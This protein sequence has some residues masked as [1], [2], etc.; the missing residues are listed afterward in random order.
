MEKIAVLL[1]VF[2]SLTIAGFSQTAKRT[3]TNSD[4]A[5]FSQKR[6]EAERE[7][8]QTYAEKGLPS[9]EEIRAQSDARVKETVE[10]AEKIQADNLERQRL[11][12]AAMQAQAQSQPIVITQGAPYYYPDYGY[13]GFGSDGIFDRFGNRFRGRSVNRRGYYAAGGV[14]WPAPITTGGT[15]FP[16]PSLARPTVRPRR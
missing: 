16:R 4:L 15:G 14:V 5:K 8:R 13:L 11:A 1:C 12:V 6:I 2:F 7:Y 3:V 9:P 10:L